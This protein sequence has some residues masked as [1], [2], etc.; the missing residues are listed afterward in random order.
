MRTTIELSDRHRGILHALSSERG[1]RGYSRI[2]EEAIDFYIEEKALKDN[3]VQEL[4]Q[5]KGSWS[6][7]EG[8]RM[9]AKLKEIREDWQI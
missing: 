2:I 9:K 7:E 1:L 4:L 5:L 8:E 3:T 6:A